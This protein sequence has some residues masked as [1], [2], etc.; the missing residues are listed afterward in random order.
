MY[1]SQLFR[2]NMRTTMSNLGMTQRALAKTLGTK[3]PHI[4]RI[5][6]GKTQ[7]S[8][9]LADRIADALGMPLPDLITKPAV[10]SRRAS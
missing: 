7:P 9:E 1:S 6:S 2:D 8:L 4:N 5:L 10:T 3:H